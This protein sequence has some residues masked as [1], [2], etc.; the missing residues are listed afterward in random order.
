MD[1]KIKTAMLMTAGLGTRLRPFTDLLPKPLLPL[2]GIPMA[3]FA[4]DALAEAGVEKVVANVH[5]LPEKLR[6]SLP[7][8]ATQAGIKE[9]R[10]SDETQ[11][12]LGSA[13]GMRNALPLL[14]EQGD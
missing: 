10:L 11:E 9:L 7:G 4:L 8:L 3:Q 2:M 14:C 5:H 6:E 12:L 1:A 13:G